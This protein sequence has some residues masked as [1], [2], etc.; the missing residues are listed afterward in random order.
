M[1]K[2]QSI[3]FADKKKPVVISRKTWDEMSDDN[4][5]AFTLL[6]A[7]AEP[8]AE[9]AQVKEVAKPEELSAGKVESKPTK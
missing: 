5:M 8:E 9:K 1:P 7:N 3:R 2:I 6:D 4:K